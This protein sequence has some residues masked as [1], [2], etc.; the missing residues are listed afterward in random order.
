[1]LEKYFELP[2]TASVSDRP[3]RPTASDQGGGEAGSWAMPPPPDLLKRVGGLEKDRVD[4]CLR[5][6]RETG[7]SLDK[8]LLQKGYLDEAK[9]LQL[10]GEYLGYEFRPELR[11]DVVPG[12]FL[13]KVPVQFAR[14]YNLCAV[15]RANGTMKVATCAPMDV[16]PMDDLSPSSAATSSRSWLRAPRSRRSSTAATSTRATS[17]TRR[18]TTWTRRTSSRSP[19][20]SRRARTCWT[21]PTRRRS[22]S[23][24]T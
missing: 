22:S 3:P 14:S 7:Q 13:R 10:F 17:S 6:Q 1:M 8:I 16:H 18:S 21:S 19:R 5:L 12:E 15:G 20:R 2:S 11:I 4:D 9:M 23:W 24:S